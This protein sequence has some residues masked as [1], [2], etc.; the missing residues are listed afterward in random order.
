MNDIVL[1][2]KHL[3]DTIEDL[4]KFAILGAGKLK[5]LKAEIQ[6]IKQLNLAKEV[7]EQKKQEAIKLQELLLDSYKKIGEFTQRL[8]KATNNNPN[9]SNQ[10]SNGQIR[11]DTNLTK[12]ETKTEIIQNLGFS[13]DQV[14]RFETL[15]KNPDLVERVKAEA[16]ESGTAP[17]MTKVLDLAK[18]RKEQIESENRRE[19]QY[20]KEYKKF[21]GIVYDIQIYEFGD[22]QI[23]AVLAA[24]FPLSDSIDNIDFA[25]R[26][27]QEMKSKLITKGVN[28]NVKKHKRNLN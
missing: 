16:K 1:S 15:A 22:L 23:E 24:P 17:T 12:S 6:A 26:N 8:P 3:P 20:H 27:L 19:S 2:E 21:C 7:Y 28:K 11:T 4:S 14:N 25:I 10:Y 5:V 18:L 13:K 9:G